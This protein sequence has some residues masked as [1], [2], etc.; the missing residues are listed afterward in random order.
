MQTNKKKLTWV[1]D[2]RDAMNTSEDWPQIYYNDTTKN[3]RRI[4]FYTNK[5]LGIDILSR[6]QEVIQKRR[7]YLNVSVKHSPGPLTNETYVYYTPK[8]QIL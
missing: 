7:P 8:V 6:I 4:K 1:G 5:P 2:I 3:Q